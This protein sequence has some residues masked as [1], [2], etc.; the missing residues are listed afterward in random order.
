MLKQ[1]I[2][3]EMKSRRKFKD[4]DLYKDRDEEMEALIGYDHLPSTLER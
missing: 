2:V 3:D 1:K 4:P